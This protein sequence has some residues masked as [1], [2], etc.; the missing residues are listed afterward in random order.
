MRRI[1]FAL[2]GVLFV[3]ACLVPAVLAQAPSS[4]QI[5]LPN[6]GMPNHAIRLT[7]VRD[8]GVQNIVF[9]DSNGIFLIA[10]PRTQNVHYTV[11]IESDG[12]TYGRTVA[13]FSQDRSSPNR[14]TVF[15]KPIEIEKRTNAVLNAGNIEENIPAKA[16]AAYKRA[17][18][19]VGSGQLESAIGGLEQAIRLYPQYVT[20]LNDLGVVFMKLKRLDEAAVAFRKATEIDKRFFHPRMN[21][22]MVLNKQGKY[23][24]A[25]EILEPLYGENHGMVEIRMAYGQALGGA[26]E[27]PEAE[28]IYRSTLEAKTLSTTTRANIYFRLGVILNREGRF[29]DAVVEFNRALAL[30]PDGANTHVQLGAAL[31]Q[32][33]QAGR[34]E[35]ELLRGYELAGSSVGIAQLLLGQIYYAE[36]K[37]GEAQRAFEQYLKDVPAAPNSTQITE[38]IAQLKVS[39]K[40]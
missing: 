30:D 4:I 10:T 37:F 32:L 18:E 28:K 29:A 2:Q 34:A 25:L 5:F 11:T 21:L 12:Q 36:K 17:M 27:L 14:T 3:I 22:G 39:S 31:M 19:S 40:N 7:L 35:R 23:R 20:A 8:D 16:R 24:E 1:S 9:T 13:S 33:Q 26:G 38:L 15:L 6:G